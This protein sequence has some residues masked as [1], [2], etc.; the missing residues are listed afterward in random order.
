[1]D[2]SLAQA[3]EVEALQAIYGDGAVAELPGHACRTLRLQL[4]PGLTVVATLPPSYGGSEAGRGGRLVPD[5]TPS[6][7]EL[8]PPGARG[9]L[10]ERA[11]A[12]AGA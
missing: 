3:D 5:F 7:T 10:P 9:Q 12:R 8:G 1:M 6:L 4:A 2:D 11:G